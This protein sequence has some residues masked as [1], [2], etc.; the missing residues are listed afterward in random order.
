MKLFFPPLPQSLEIDTADSRMSP[1]R[2]PAFALDQMET[3]R[4]L[5]GDSVA[6]A[7]FN[8]GELTAGHFLRTAS[9]CM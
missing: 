9:G 5:I 1:P 8:R 7:E 3:L 4:P 6:V 2:R